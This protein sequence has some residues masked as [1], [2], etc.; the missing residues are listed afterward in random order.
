MKV[1][2]MW[3]A[4]ETA[5]IALAR[6]READDAMMRAPAKRLSLRRRAQPFAELDL[7]RFTEDFVC[8]STFD[9]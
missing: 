4:L 9:D 7:R 6:A 1:G 2:N 5:V 3:I 8:G